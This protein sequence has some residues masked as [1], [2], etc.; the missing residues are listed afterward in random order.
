MINVGLG[1]EKV[2]EVVYLPTYVP[3]YPTH[4]TAY[5]RPVR[6]TTQLRTAHARETL[7][8]RPNFS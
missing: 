5:V 6:A 1:K 2:P 3:T 7:L 4:L 8:C